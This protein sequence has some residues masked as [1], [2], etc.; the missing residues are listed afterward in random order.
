MTF[1]K[2]LLPLAL[3]A[4]LATAALVGCPAQMASL[5]VQNMT[6]QDIIRLVVAC[7][8]D[9]LATS[10]DQLVGGR[11]LPS[12][13]TYTVTNIPAGSYDLQAVFTSPPCGAGGDV[14]IVNLDADLLTGAWR[15]LLADTAGSGSCEITE[16]LTVID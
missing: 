10:P 15:W 9:D 12:G 8:G 11:T 13:E 6:S 4:G 16:A 5:E 3:I 2:K 1:T 7:D 14:S